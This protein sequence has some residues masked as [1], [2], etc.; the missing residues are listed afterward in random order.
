MA[1]HPLIE[2]IIDNHV[3]V[4]ADCRGEGAVAATADDPDQDPDICLEC[5]G[6]GKVRITDCA[7]VRIPLPRNGISWADNRLLLAYYLIEEVSGQWHPEDG[8]GE[9]LRRALGDIETADCEIEEL[10][11]PHHVN[12]AVPA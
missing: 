12:R 3:A 7:T 1:L 6:T 5:N 9:A 8:V 11:R 4:C 2:Q 10:T